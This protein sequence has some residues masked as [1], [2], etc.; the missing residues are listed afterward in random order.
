MLF[1]ASAGLADLSQTLLALRLEADSFYKLRA[2]SGALSDLKARLAALKTRR[3]ESDTY[4]TAYAELVAVRDKARLH[5]DATLADRARIRARMDEIGRHAAALPRLSALRSLREQLRPLADLPDVSAAWAGELP[6]IERRDIE[7][8]AELKGIDADIEAL[9]TALGGSAVDEAAL[10]L[11][12]RVARLVESRARHLTAEKDLPERRL[13]AR[14][15]S[16]AIASLLGRLGAPPDSDPREVTLAAPAVG[17]LRALLESRS[18]VASTVA[19]AE[20]ERDTAERA[21]WEARDRLK[22]AGGGGSVADPSRLAG[23]V[24]ALRGGDHTTRRIVAERALPR[25]REALAKCLQALRPW[26]G[27]VAQ[28]DALVLPDLGSFERLAKARDEARDRVAREVADIDRLSGE[29]RRLMAEVDALEAIAGVVGEVEAAAI[30][31]ARERAWAEHRRALEI[32][33]AD[34]FEDL[35]RRDDLV[36]SARLGRAGEVAKLQQT[37]LTLAGVEVDLARARESH[38]AAERRRHGVLQEIEAALGL[39]VPPLP[40]DIDAPQLGA[41]MARRREALAAEAAVIEAERERSHAE[42]DA[43]AAR[44]RIVEAL[45]EAGVPHEPEARF[46]R[47]IADAQA[48]LDREVGLQAMRTM[49]EERRRALEDRE[50]RLAK[51]RRAEAGW[52]AAWAAACAGCW[53]GRNGAEPS[54]DA[55]REVLKVLAELTPVLQAQGDLAYRI[56]AMEKDQAAFATDVSG[57]AAAL[58]IP[59]VGVGIGDLDDEIG[60]RVRQAGQDEE[61][62]LKSER[63]LAGARRRRLAAAAAGAANLARKAEMTGF[64]GVETLIEVGQRLRA[65]ERRDDLGRQ[66]KTVEQELRSA[67]R[68]DDVEAAERL[69]DGLDPAT[70]DAESIELQARFDDLDARTRS[71]FAEHAKAFDAVEA[72]GGD[73]AVARIEEER[74][75][76]LLDIEDQARHYLK[77][78][79]GIA[80]AEQALRSYRDRHRSAMMERASKA[81]AV[82]SRNAYRGLVTQPDKDVEILMGVAADGSTK[83]ASELSKGTRFQLYLALRIAGYLE[84]SAARRVVPFIADDIMET[85]DDFRAE[86][87]FR[88]FSGMAEVGQVIYLTHHH[89]LCDIA[90]E[91]CPSVRIHDL[92]APPLSLAS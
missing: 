70:L 62:R 51:A 69:L 54:A 15:S 21:L 23:V 55:V 25:L 30:R 81:F 88:L 33:S 32:V 73:D 36:T 91:A 26:S 9:S 92:S 29:R 2:R 16:L 83:V 37:S 41:W 48:S 78:R 68:F 60:R 34:S 84:F 85:F 12:P 31:A 4:A 13:A 66:A 27:D 46:D 10:R 89:H 67:L 64:F 52:A 17:T 57:L 63:D 80:S 76:T 59:T 20:D 24:A 79:A 53:L 50:R 35:L 45:L 44:D 5:Y 87:A 6:D 77:L 43:D 11:S 40:A 74:R 56:A 19:V 90:R 82:I 1:S 8:A 3:E 39:V 49:I 42:A 61:A 22:E 71:H 14:A 75:T 28:L 47:L 65:I 58:N 38:A 18:G 72:V 7:A 86:E